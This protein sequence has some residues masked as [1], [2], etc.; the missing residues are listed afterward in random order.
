MKRGAKIGLFYGSSVMIFLFS[1]GSLMYA[2]VNILAA[3]ENVNT[4]D[5]VILFTV[6]VWSGWIAGN[7][8][9]F[10]SHVSAGKQSAKN[11]FAILDLKSES[12][13]HQANVKPMP[14]EIKGKI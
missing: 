5:F 11:I 3:S 2:A 4:I 7:N 6:P 14:N 1:V 13:L 9:F 12:S 8:F 10:A